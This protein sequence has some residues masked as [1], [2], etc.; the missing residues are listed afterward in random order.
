MARVLIAYETKHGSTLHTAGEM[1]E[2]CG[3]HGRANGVA[4]AGKEHRARQVA[5]CRHRSA[6]P[7]QGAK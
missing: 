6:L 7:V 4:G 2:Q 5:A 3:G 1:A